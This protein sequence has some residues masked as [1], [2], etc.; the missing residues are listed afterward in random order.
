MTPDVKSSILDDFGVQSND[1]N[2]ELEV[3]DHVG[4]SKYKNNLHKVTFQIG[5]KNFFSL[6]KSKIVCR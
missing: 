5:L 4:I 3:S 1:K 2:P 6:N